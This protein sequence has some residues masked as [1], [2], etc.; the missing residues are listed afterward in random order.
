MSTVEEREARGKKCLHS[1]R[2]A[3][4]K[5]NGEPKLAPNHEDAVRERGVTASPGSKAKKKK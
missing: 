3:R 1:A 2:E 5:T 4:F